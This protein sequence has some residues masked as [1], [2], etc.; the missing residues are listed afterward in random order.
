MVSFQS[1]LKLNPSK[2]ATMNDGAGFVSLLNPNN[3]GPSSPSRL[4]RWMA[5]HKCVRVVPSSPGIV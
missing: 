3:T 5:W 4:T 2:V 1:S